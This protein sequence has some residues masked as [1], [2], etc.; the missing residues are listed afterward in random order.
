[1]VGTKDAD[2]VNYFEYTILNGDKQTYHNSWVTDIPITSKNIADLVK[3]RA[4]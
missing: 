4:R 2:D 3:G 1:L